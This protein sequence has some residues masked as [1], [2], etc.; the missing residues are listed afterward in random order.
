MASENHIPWTHLCAVKTN[1]L[2]HIS[3]YI[4]VQVILE[5]K[6]HNQRNEWKNKTLA[7]DL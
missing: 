3:A 1:S 6:H 2:P 7:S 5:C 4:N